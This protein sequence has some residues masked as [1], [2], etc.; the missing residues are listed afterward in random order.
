MHKIVR[1]GIES[2][3]DDTGGIEPGDSEA[4]DSVEAGK[5]SANHDTAVGLQRDGTDLV[6]GAGIRATG[7]SER[8]IGCATFEDAGQTVELTGR[9]GGNLPKGPREPDF[10][11]RPDR[12]TIDAAIQE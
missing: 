1:R 2:R 11:V 4:H 6:V 8:R 12:E 10:P 7:R 5:A 9:T 3:I